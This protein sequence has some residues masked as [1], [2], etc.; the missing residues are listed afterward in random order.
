MKLKPCL[1]LGHFGEVLKYL[2]N[3]KDKKDIN[4]LL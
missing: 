1:I 2:E 3:K 4:E